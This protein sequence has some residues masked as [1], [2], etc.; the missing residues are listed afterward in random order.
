MKNAEYTG[1]AEWMAVTRHTTTWHVSW[2]EHHYIAM[3]ARPYVDD[4]L[5]ATDIIPSIVD[6]HNVVFVHVFLL[7]CNCLP[8]L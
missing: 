8:L 3:P 6:A 5:I 7:E 1:I 2:V 4:V